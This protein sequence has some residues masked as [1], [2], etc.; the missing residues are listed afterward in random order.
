[1][2]GSL[3]PP[4]VYEPGRILYGQYWDF[5]GQNGARN[6]STNLSVYP[7]N[8]QNCTGFNSTG[9]NTSLW[10]D[11]N[12]I[13][14]FI[15]TSNFT[16][17]GYETISN[18]SANTSLGTSDILYPTQNAVKV[19]VDN[20][21]AVLNITKLDKPP[22]VCTNSTFLQNFNGTSTICSNTPSSGSLTYYFQNTTSTSTINASKQ[23][24][25]TPNSTEVILTT[26]GVVNNQILQNWTTEPGFP[27]LTFIP[28]GSY[29]CHIHS[30]RT[31]NPATA[32]SLN[33]QIWEVNS[34]GGQL[35]LIGTTETSTP[36][37]TTESEYRLSLV[38]IN[39]TFL[40]SNT[41]RI[42]IQI[43]TT[44]VSGTPDIHL[45]IGGEADAHLS[46]PSNTVD[47][48]NF[49]PYNGA[50]G[51]VNIGTHSLTAQNLSGEG[52]KI[53]N[54]SSSQIIDFVSNVRTSISIYDPDKDYPIFYN[55][56]TGNITY[57]ISSPT[58]AGFLSASDFTNFSNKVNISGD[59][60]TGDLNIINTSTGNVINVNI[61]YPGAANLNLANQVMG[62]GTFNNPSTG[63]S[64]GY[65]ATGI[66]DS[67]FQFTSL[68][69]R[70]DVLD[71]TTLANFLAKKA[72]VFRANGLNQFWF[73]PNGTMNTNGDIYPQVNDTYNLGR[74]GFN[75]KQVYAITFAGGEYADCCYNY[76]N[77]FNWSWKTVWNNQSIYEDNVLTG[78][79]ST[80]IG[81]KNTSSQEWSPTDASSYYYSAVMLNS[82]T[83]NYELAKGLGTSKS[84][85]IIPADDSLIEGEN[86]N[87]TMKGRLVI[88]GDYHVKATGKV[89][90]GDKLIVSNTEGVLQSAY[91]LSGI[92]SLQYNFTAKAWQ[93]VTLPTSTNP[94]VYNTYDRAQGVDATVV[95]I[96]YESYNSS[97]VGIIEAKVLNT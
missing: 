84:V 88:L 46:L 48:T 66:F 91:N 26:T 13:C 93:Y 74:A 71:N 64:I 72:L 8:F 9:F 32:A 44:A 29:E 54:I 5:G 19:Y 96:A 30:N 68:A 62:N 10:N 81:W 21:T 40:S 7:P 83:G 59:T 42:M 80:L 52:S 73:F 24:L 37:P 35:Q 43:V 97:D 69:H 11:T 78:G 4:T 86:I 55:N 70:T 60:M 14:A 36:L 15:P 47:A 39:T 82:T 25:V 65:Q 18:K 3:N 90:I 77:I 89:N 16:I 2:I 23:M 85:A 92:Q 63:F 79:N 12:L 76:S 94:N 49:V 28:A 17:A 95:A 45:E 56:T 33:C 67:R 31:G 53:T 22:V 61:S 75:Y 41:S 58:Q 34:T 87:G 27:G 1:M 38:T 6:G 20:Q 50:T 51:A 57:N